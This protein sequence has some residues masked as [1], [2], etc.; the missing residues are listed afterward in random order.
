MSIW[1]QKPAARGQNWLPGGAI[2]AEFTVVSEK[3]GPQTR[4]PSPPITTPLYHW[5]GAEAESL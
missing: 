2:D 5:L 1:I 4:L 3:P